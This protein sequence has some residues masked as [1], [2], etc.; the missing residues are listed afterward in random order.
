MGTDTDDDDPFGSYIA[1]QRTQTAVAPSGDPPLS[2]RQLAQAGLT[3]TEIARALGMPL[4]TVQAS[5]DVLV[6]LGAEHD[7]RV[8]RA[9]YHAAVGGERWTEKLDKFGDVH[10][11]AEQVAPDPRAA[12][13]YLENRQR[14]AWGGT[15]KEAVRVVVV[16]EMPKLRDANIFDA[17]DEIE[18]SALPGADAR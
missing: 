16:R 7:A 12:S 11:L 1:L 18:N 10:R 8:A 15:V 2:I 6:P 3:D 13:F 17:S 9:I 5:P 14:A 4:E